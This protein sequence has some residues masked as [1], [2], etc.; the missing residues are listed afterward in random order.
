MLIIVKSK[1]TIELCEIL[2]EIPYEE[3]GPYD[4][5]PL[6]ERHPAVESIIEQ[7]EKHIKLQKLE[8]GEE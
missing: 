1:H 2:C 7:L 4:M 8:E 6:T 3:A 5:E